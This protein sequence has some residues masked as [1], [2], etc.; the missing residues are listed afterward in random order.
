MEL[1]ILDD[2]EADCETK[3]PK[4]KVAKKRGWTAAQFRELR[5]K[6]K[7]D[8]ARGVRGAKK[9]LAARSGSRPSPVVKAKSFQKATKGHHSVL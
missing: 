8:V 9:K 3:V 7:D 5:Q 6:L 4:T 1:A 2:A